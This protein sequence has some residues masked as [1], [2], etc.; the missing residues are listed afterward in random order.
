MRKC[1]IKNLWFSICWWDLFRKATVI[2]VFSGLGHGISQNYS[3][4]VFYP[5]SL[6]CWSKVGIE[7]PLSIYHSVVNYVGRK[8]V[9]LLISIQNMEFYIFCILIFV[10]S[11]SFSQ[12]N[13]NG[14]YHFSGSFGY[15]SVC[16]VWKPILLL[17]D[18]HY[19]GY[20][21]YYYWK[22]Q[23]IIEPIVTYAPA[24]CSSSML[25]YTNPDQNYW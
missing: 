5:I 7:K 19:H 3:L 17:A 8:C 14:N 16:Q 21:G 15:G 2:H 9:N 20:T 13:K 10:T 22:T 4:S 18:V 1:L 12:N 11:Y 23:T 6:Q 25:L 24:Y